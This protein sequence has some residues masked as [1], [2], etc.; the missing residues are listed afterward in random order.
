MME[1]KSSLL[2]IMCLLSVMP[3]YAHDTNT[4][5]PELSEQIYE[6]I[7]GQDKQTASYRYH[8]LYLTYEG[9]QTEQVGLATYQ[10]DIGE[11]YPYLWGYDPRFSD[12]KQKKFDEE[13]DT[14]VAYRAF[15]KPSLNVM[16]GVVMEDT[17][18]GRVFSYFQ[19]AYSGIEM[20]LDWKGVDFFLLREADPDH[21][22]TLTSF[23]QVANS[24]ALPI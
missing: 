18:L 21:I 8:Q 16:D 5:H 19:H 23:N 14:G 20:T 4:T 10:R 17:P 7:K 2:R 9:Y 13:P 3:V 6:S 12:P 15:R 1:F 24:M 22:K 11:P